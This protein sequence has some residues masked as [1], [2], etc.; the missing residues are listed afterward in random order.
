MRIFHLS[1]LWALCCNYLLAQDCLVSGWLKDEKEQPIS[2]ACLVLEGKNKHCL[3]DEKGFFTMKIPCDG[4]S[5]VMIRHVG[6]EP[7]LL[8]TQA[9]SSPLTL[10]LESK[11]GEIDPI[12]ISGTRY[13]TTLDDTPLPIS[14][15]SGEKIKAM[16]SFRLSDVLA[17]QTGMILVSDHGT[18]LQLQGFNPDYT[19]IMI[20]GQPLIGRVSG[21]FELERIT[22]GNIKRIEITKG[23]ASSLYGSEA[24]AGVVNI[25]TDEPELPFGIHL[26]SRYKTFNTTD[27]NLNIESKKKNTSFIVQL[28]HYHTDGYDL[29]PNTISK[30]RPRYESYTVNGRF[31]HKISSKNHVWID[32]RFF[33][34]NAKNKNEVSEE[35]RLFRINDSNKQFD[36]NL[37]P[38]WIYK[39]TARIKLT[40]LNYSSYYDARTNQTYESKSGSFYEGS[41][42]QFFNRT[43]TMGEY[44]I[45]HHQKSTAGLGYIV[46]GLASTR[47]NAPG[48]FVTK[49]VFAQHDLNLFQNKLNILSGL[50]FDQH[51]EYSEQL[52]PKLSA[53][54]K[55]SE[56]YKL[57]GSVGMG[58]KAPDFRQLF[59]DFTN[60]TAGYSVFGSSNVKSNMEQLENSGQ[61]QSI[62]IDYKN[63]EKIKA[64]RSLAFNFGQEIKLGKV[65]IFKT[66]LF[67]HQVT[68]L[69]ESQPIALKTNGSQVFTYFN[70]S[71]VILQ[72]LEQEVYIYPF[73]NIEISIGYQYLDAKDRQVIEN[74]RNGKVFARDENNRT[75]RVKPEQYGG[76][77][78]R[79]KHSGNFKI[80]Y[81]VPKWKTNISYRLVARGRFGISDRNGNGILDAENEYSKGFLTSH[82]Q[83]A[84]KFGEKEM[85]GI[86]LGADNLFDVRNEFVPTMPG[87]LLFIGVNYSWAKRLDK[88]NKI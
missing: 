51:S 19:L 84:K 49:Y 59:L 37:T 57:K 26:Q 66:N 7:F 5:R 28:N 12:I 76:L 15:I 34:Q 75:Y 64:E 44:F 42:K 4:Q 22:V 35:G 60:A 71:S 72:G 21:T 81:K 63:L 55:L 25:I 61:I 38:T 8:E 46:E 47:Y 62:L 3:S 23:P 83:I 50:R 82:F 14:V 1:Y 13:E 18:G 65:L 39:P 52:S 58:F 31:S 43:E 40:T 80:F 29:N 86:Q 69:I 11:I 87:R 10:K 54:Y 30:T 2:E 73:K 45:N 27:N 41:F 20:N 74:L 32:A 36:F 9:S 85:F 79:S 33:A 16:G 6:F 56:A 53:Q 24:L 70:L 48:N 78:N 88:L 68:N 17:E 77:F 67:R